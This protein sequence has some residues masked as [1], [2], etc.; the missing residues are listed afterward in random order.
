MVLP[1]F[2]LT[3]LAGFG[4]GLLVG[5]LG[6][7]KNRWKEKEEGKSWDWERF[8]L[9]VGIY[10]IGGTIAGVMSANIYEALIAGLAIEK[11]TK[12]FI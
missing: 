9:T 8:L 12:I 1:N 7:T 4:G 6:Y 11:V 10:T 5:L 3:G 2:V